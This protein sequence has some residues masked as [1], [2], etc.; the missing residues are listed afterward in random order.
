MGPRCCCYEHA[1]DN[2]DCPMTH[3]APPDPRDAIVRAAVA[4]RHAHRDWWASQ[5][6]S[7]HGQEEAQERL[8]A[9]VDAL[10][11]EEES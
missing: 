2:A 7:Y 9:A 1:G 6:G 4:F 11:R 5:G 10:E 3:V 8:F